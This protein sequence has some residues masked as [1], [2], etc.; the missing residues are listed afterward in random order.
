M[1]QLRSRWICVADAGVELRPI[2]IGPISAHALGVEPSKYEE[3]RCTDY[4]EN[5][6]QH[7]LAVW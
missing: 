7:E 6:K 3:Q 5:T 2:G 4:T 1:G